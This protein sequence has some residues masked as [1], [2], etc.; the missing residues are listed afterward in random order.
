VATTQQAAVLTEHY[1]VRL[2]VTFQDF[3]VIMKHLEPNVAINLMC[4][5]Y[6]S[7]K[8]KQSS[9]IVLALDLGVPQVIEEFF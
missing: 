7:Y 5:T 6:C 9:V 3:R 4:K 2:Y 8:G 1:F